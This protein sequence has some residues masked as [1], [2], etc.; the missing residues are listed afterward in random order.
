MNIFFI[1]RVFRIHYKYKAKPIILQT[2]KD[3]WLSVR[4]KLC[5]HN[6]RANTQDI[7]ILLF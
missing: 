3:E 6:I 1:Y 5:K 2:K 7:T 4:Q